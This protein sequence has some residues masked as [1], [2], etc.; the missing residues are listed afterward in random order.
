LVSEKFPHWSRKYIGLLRS[1][2]LT[3]KQLKELFLK[4]NSIKFNSMNSLCKKTKLGIKS[5]VLL[6]KETL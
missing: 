1:K 4:V 5:K 2:I 6:V 3:L